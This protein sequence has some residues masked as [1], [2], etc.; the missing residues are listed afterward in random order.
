[1]ASKKNEIT[2]AELLTPA[3]VS[4]TESYLAARVAAEAMREQVDALRTPLLT[5]IEL[6]ADLSDGRRITAPR[7]YWL[8]EDNA[9]L[10]RY[11]QE[12][13]RREKAA[14]LKPD[15]MPV[16]SCPALVLEEAQLAAEHELITASGAPFGIDN[17]KLLCGPDGLGRRQKWLDLVVGL[18]LAARREGRI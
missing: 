8:S 15:D 4:L 11:Y 9:A 2:N 6:Y 18:V 7:D 14:G 3:I 16:D 1:M 10:A 12:C 5:E 17:D 13:D